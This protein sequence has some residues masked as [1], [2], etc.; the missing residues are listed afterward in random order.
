MSDLTTLTPKQIDAQLAEVYIQQ[1]AAQRD[2]EYAVAAIHRAVGD[3]RTRVGGYGSR[4]FEWGLDFEDALHQATQWADPAFGKD[5]WD[6]AKAQ[7]ALDKWTA[8]QDRLAELDARDARFHSEFLRRGGW[9]RAFIVDKGHVHSSMQCSTC[10]PSTRYSWLPELSDDDEDEIVAKA[11]ERACTICYPSAP[12]DVLKRKSTLFSDEEKQANA[13]R[14]SRAAAKAAKVAKAREN[15]PTITGETLEVKT[16]MFRETFKTER[17][18]VNF[19]HREQ[20]F[21]FFYGT[22]DQVDIDA[23]SIVLQAVAEKRGI[24]PE[25][26]RDEVYV[27]GLA[28]FK[29]QGWTVNHDM[30]VGS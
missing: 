3:D 18:A 21:T 22:R 27:K 8:V 10:Y 20:E 30:K 1:F 13:E 6:R 14:E 28:K 26:L 19:L 9:T 15:A 23:A 29:R 7:E 12:V 5:T 17:A 16:S 25:A 2:L 24:S 4:R 11:G